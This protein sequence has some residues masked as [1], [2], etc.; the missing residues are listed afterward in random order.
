VHREYVVEILDSES[1]LQGIASEWLALWREDRRATPFQSPYW[2]LAWW[3][4]LSTGGTLAVVAVRDRGELVGL[5]PWQAGDLEGGKRAVRFIGGGI[6]DYLDVLSKPHYWIR[7]GEDVA[8][9]VLRQMRCDEC[10]FDEL[11]PES[12]LLNGV[13]HDLLKHV[14]RRSPCPVLALTGSDDQPGGAIPQSTSRAVGYYR[15]RLGRTHQFDIEAANPQNIDYLLH[16]LIRLHGELWS[17]R[18]QAGVLSRREIADFHHEAATGLLRAGALRLYLLRIH[19]RSA[20]VFYGFCWHQ[21]TYYYLGGFAPEFARLNPGTL[22]I[23][24]AIEQATREGSCEFNFL[25]G[26]E[27]YKYWWGAHDRFNYR[28]H[29]PGTALNSLCGFAN[30]TS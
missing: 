30:Q 26:G 8:R 9:N 12:P 13:S 11:R 7:W 24:H 22:V 19:G 14:E 6:T 20:A 10:D 4:H 16:E 17:A 21:R 28:L 23:D 5:A 27:G 25:R 2:N 29:V 3:R 1:D 15:R 18:G